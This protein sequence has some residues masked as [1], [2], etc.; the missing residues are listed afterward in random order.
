ML[1]FSH[2]ARAAMQVTR[3]ADGLWI[4]S[5]PHPA[6]KPEFD[7]PDGWARSVGSVYFESPSGPVLIDPLVPADQDE[8]GRL[9]AALDRDLARLGGSVVILIGCVEHGRSADLIAA[10]Y[11]ERGVDVAVRGDDAIRSAVS[12]RLTGALDASHLPAGVRA[13]PVP[14]L[15]PGETAFFLDGPKALV[16]AD[17]VIGAGD[18]AVRLAPPSWGVRTDA[19]VALYDRAFHPA[20]RS[21]LALDPL[22]LLPSHGPPVLENGAAAL[23]AALAVPPWGVC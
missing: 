17:A 4:W 10:R 14:G 5:A 9:W 8:A 1:A 7:R 2:E 18:G 6:W 3:I 15:S 11:R 16:F 20:L 21:L 22:L 13:Y 23:R 19:G 12:C